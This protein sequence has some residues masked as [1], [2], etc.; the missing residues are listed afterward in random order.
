MK[1]CYYMKYYYNLIINILGLQSFV[2]E[3][4]RNYPHKL[5]LSNIYKWEIPFYLKQNPRFNFSNYEV[6][7][8]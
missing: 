7:N 2:I 6:V 1:N 8:K 5:K 4:I 3:F